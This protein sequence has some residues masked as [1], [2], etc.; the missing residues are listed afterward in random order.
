MIVLPRGE[1]GSWIL[2]RSPSSQGVVKKPS[3]LAVDVHA[4][5]RRFLM[6]RVRRAYAHNRGY[7]FE[8]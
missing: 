5:S 3:P 7:D 2:V 1:V 6:L 8:Y 4:P